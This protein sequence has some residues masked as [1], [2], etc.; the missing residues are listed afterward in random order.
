MKVTDSG[1]DGRWSL[2]P[3]PD[4]GELGLSDLHR[5]C[6]ALALNLEGAFQARSGRTQ[7]PPFKLGVIHRG[8]DINYL[9]AP[10]P[11]NKRKFFQVWFVFPDLKIN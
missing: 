3:T 7:R 2:A 10:G 9:P 11:Q 6:R 4:P 8:V 1:C 5:G